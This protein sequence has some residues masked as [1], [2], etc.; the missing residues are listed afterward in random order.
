MAIFEDITL[1]WKGQDYTLGGDVSIMKTLAQVEDVITYSRLYQATI[2]NDLPLIKITEAY[3]IVLRNA[4]CKVTHAEVYQ[5]VMRG[6]AD[7]I[8]GTI[9]ALLFM[10]MPPEQIAE[11]NTP[12]DTGK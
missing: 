9:N 3:C 10:M 11:S 6:A 5:S 4:G 1:T 7:D 12:T 8:L 2:N